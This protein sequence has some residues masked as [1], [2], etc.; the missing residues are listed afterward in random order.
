MANE[1]PI[2]GS[3]QA[4]FASPALDYSEDGIDLEKILRPRPS[5]FYLRAV[6]DSM[7]GAQIPPGAILVVDKALQP[8]NYSII[9]ACI[10][11]EFLVKYF[12]KDIKGPRLESANPK[13]APVIITEDMQFQVWGVVTAVVILTK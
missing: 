4:G 12:V 3:V 5:V 10:N 7:I 11:G 9:I 2:L 13:Y 8:R 6:N 1:L